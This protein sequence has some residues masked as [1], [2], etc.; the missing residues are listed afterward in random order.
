[1]SKFGNVQKNK[2][3]KAYNKNNSLKQKIKMSARNDFTRYICMY[4]CIYA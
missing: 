2:N 1:M 4:V 3:K